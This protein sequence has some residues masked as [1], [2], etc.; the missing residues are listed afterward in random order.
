MSG[1]VYEQ[2]TLFPEVSLVSRSPLP[3]SEEARMMTVTSGQKCLE[4][5]KNSGPLGLLEKMFLESSAWH[6]TMYLMTWKPKATRREHL[7]FRLTLSAHGTKETGSRLLPTVRSHEAGDYQYS[8][9]NHE[10]KILTLTGR[11]KL[12]ATPKASDSKGTG[13]IG[14]KSAEHDLK[15]GNLKGQVLYATPQRSRNLNNQIVGQLNPEWTEWL[16]G[17]PIGW[18]EI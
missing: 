15:K 11:A 18:T 4:L 1:Q 14:S 2:L 16:M 13:P 3:G 6:S 9:G 7:Y 10:K 17:Y 5:S 12:Y 8:Q